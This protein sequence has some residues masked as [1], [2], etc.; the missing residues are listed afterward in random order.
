MKRCKGSKNSSTQRIGKPM[1]TH[2]YVGTYYST[3]IPMNLDFLG[4][5]VVSLYA[6]LKQY[7]DIICAS[8]RE[9]VLLAARG[10]HSNP[11]SVLL[12]M[13]STL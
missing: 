13:L 9:K 10:A 11:L 4:R 3:V 2:I 1:I 5:T 6:E 8:C 12:E 7:R